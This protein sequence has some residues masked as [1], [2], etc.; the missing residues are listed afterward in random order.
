MGRQNQLSDDF[1]IPENIKQ[2]GETPIHRFN[3]FRE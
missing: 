2:V 1:K 3:L